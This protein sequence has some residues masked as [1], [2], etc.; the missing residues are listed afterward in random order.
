MW[1]TFF[2]GVAIGAVF[3]SVPGYIIARAFSLQRLASLCAAPALSLGLYALAATALS[4]AGVFCTWFNVFALVLAV[5]ALIFVL[6]FIWRRRCTAFNGEPY[7]YERRDWGMLATYV[8]IGII[9][10]LFVLVK[11]FDGPE[12]FGLSFDNAYH[13]GRVRGMVE[14]GNWAS[15]GSGID[16]YFGDTYVT[17]NGM[18]DK[19]DLSGFYPSGWHVV[20]AMI[21][22]FLGSSTVLANNACIVAFVA[23]AFPAGMFLLART[24]FPENHTAQ[25]C[26]GLCMMCFGAFQ[27]WMIMSALMSNLAGMCLI[28]AAAAIFVQTFSAGASFSQRVQGLLLTAACVLSLGFAQPNCVFTLELFLFPYCVYRLWE[29]AAEAPVGKARKKRYWVIVGFVVLVGLVWV[30]LCLSSFMR[31]IINGAYRPAYASVTQSLVNILSLSYRWGNAQPLLGVTVIAGIVLALKKREYRWLVASYAIMAFLFFYSSS[32]DGRLDKLFTGFWYTDQQRVAAAA[33]LFA[34]PLA[35]IGLSAFVCWV[36]GK[37]KQAKL[38][39]RAR[40][41]APVA[42]M[43]LFLA[44]VFSPS[45]TVQG[46]IGV[47]TMFGKLIAHYSDFYNEHIDWQWYSSDEREFMEKVAEEVDED[48][49]IMNIPSDGSAFA[50]GQDGLKMLYRTHRLGATEEDELLRGHLDEIAENDEVREAAEASGL[51]YVL[52][53]DYANEKDGNVHHTYDAEDW[54]GVDVITEDTPGF[55]LVLQD[56]DKRLYRITETS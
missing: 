20:A 25:L 4:V 56:G 11:Q 8:L 22:S 27:W 3:I 6:S 42:V 51:K 46:Y 32:F 40:A 31:P 54:Q 45:Y 29:W 33:A 12:S 49:I 34:I 44:I 30:A 10:T 17:P 2:A 16:L 1:P 36:Q 47:E 43:A 19:S 38:G 28:P 26:T 35:G 13:L 21:A 48:D 37:C 7:R 39:K 15:I 41:A 23:I 9:V 55:E 24:L 50:Y 5:S 14:W 53:L 52:F 18:V